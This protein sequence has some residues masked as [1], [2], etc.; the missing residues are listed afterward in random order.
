MTLNEHWI[1]TASVWAN[2]ISLIGKKK[3]DCRTHIVTRVVSREQ[4]YEKS[5][6]DIRDEMLHGRET[7]QT[8]PRFTLISVT[9][10]TPSQSHGDNTLRYSQSV[11]RFYK[12][13]RPSPYLTNTSETRGIPELQT[14]GNMAIKMVSSCSC[15]T[16]P[17]SPWQ[18]ENDVDAVTV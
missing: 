2:L 1:L 12:R 4:S 14:R 5:I 10:T 7:K 9:V 13:P 11:D 6:R 18:C 8:S 15:P 16:G 3:A 17:A